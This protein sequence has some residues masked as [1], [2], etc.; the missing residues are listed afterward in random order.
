MLPLESLQLKIKT[1][2]AQLEEKLPG[3]VSSLEEIRMIIQRDPE[4]IH[5]LKTE[6]EL[7][8]IFAAMQKYQDI[9]IPVVAAKAEKSKLI[10]KNLSLND[11]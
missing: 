1:L 11:F 9:E 8:V 5:L 2:E 3:Y 4:V 6:E 10:P 7:H